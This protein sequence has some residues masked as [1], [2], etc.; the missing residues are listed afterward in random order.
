M[1]NIL[2]LKYAVEVERTGSIS[3]AAENLYMGQP[4]LSKAIRELEKTLGIS[5]FNRTSKGVIPTKKGEEF[6]NYA[7]NIIFQIEEMEAI[8]KP[9]DDS[10]HKFDI[11]VPRASYISFAFTEFVK[12]LDARK[13]I[14]LNY[15]ETNSMS[16]IKNVSDN[17]NNMAIIRYQTIYERYFLNALEERELKYDL[18]WEFEYLAL[19][20]DKHPLA[21]KQVIDYSELIKHTEI[22]HGDTTVPAFPISK[23]RQMVKADERKK[24]ISVYERGS[25]FELLS[26]IPTTYMLVSPMP[27]YILSCFS[28][29]QKPCNMSK[30]K[31]RDCF[32]YRKG[33]RMTNEDM[34]L[35]E[36]LHETVEIVSKL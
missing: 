29:V 12:N 2:H 8:Y 21:N 19:M 20:S 5:I 10:V 16:A 35:I 14:D 17:I 7:K 27:K 4:H 15:R 13:K 24:K 34:L 11:S 9:S 18:I 30:N 31:Y 32:I 28:L 22:M 1:N 6:L 3:K 33:Y 26:Q 25:Q 23:A 36:K